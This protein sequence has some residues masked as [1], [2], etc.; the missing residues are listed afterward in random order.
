ME[1]GKLKSIT[2]TIPNPWMLFG[3]VA[4]AISGATRVRFD[5]DPA[6]F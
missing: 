6:G 5:P 4:G 3:S 2:R 1:A